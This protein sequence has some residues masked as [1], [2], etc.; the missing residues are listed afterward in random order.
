MG[1]V[2]I[3]S[4]ENLNKE[5]KKVITKEFKNKELIKAINFELAEKI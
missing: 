3:H 2:F 5:L 4:Q 1:E